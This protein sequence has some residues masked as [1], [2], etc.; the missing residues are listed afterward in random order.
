MLSVILRPS[1]HKTTFFTL[2]WIYI[3]SESSASLCRA[4]ATC[5]HRKK[6]SPFSINLKFGSILNAVVFN[7]ETVAKFTQERVH[8]IY[9]V[10][11]LIYM[12]SR[13]GL[14]SPTCRSTCLVC[15]K[16]DQTVSYLEYI[17]SVSS[18]LR[19]H[20]LSLR[21]RPNVL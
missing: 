3:V 1:F 21:S 16:K 13:R 19:D 2:L 17:C 5:Y 9:S 20:G 12:S 15:R 7:N 6:N 14:I 8:V 11:T 4:Q 10:H 18:P